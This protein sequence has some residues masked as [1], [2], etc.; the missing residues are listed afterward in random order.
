MVEAERQES[1]ARGGDGIAARFDGGT[2]RLTA[3]PKLKMDASGLTWCVRVKP[4][5]KTLDGGL[6]I[7]SGL[8]LNIELAAWHMPWGPRWNL[9]FF[10]ATPGRVAHAPLMPDQDG[11]W[12]DIVVRVHPLSFQ[13][14]TRITKSFAGW[15]EIFVNGVLRVRRPYSGPGSGYAPSPIQGMLLGR[16]WNDR[17]FL[18]L[19]D[20][21]AVWQRTLTDAEIASLSGVQALDLSL[22]PEDNTGGWHQD[23]GAGFFPPDMPHQQRLDRIRDRTVPAVK[24]LL[25]SDPQFPRYHLAP[26]GSIY[27]THLFHDKGV[28]HMFPTV[29]VGPSGFVSNEQLF[30]MHLTSSDLMSW[31]PHAAH[32]PKPDFEPNGAFFVDA[33]NRVNVVG[34]GFKPFVMQGIATDA[35]LDRWDML[36]R[37]PVPADTPK[38]VKRLDPAV[39]RHQGKWY[40]AATSIDRGES[41]SRIHLLHLS[42]TRRAAL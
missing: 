37:P 11:G 15:T 2:M 33:K 41:T 17:R 22:P 21:L 12:M 7:A 14:P 5:A 28:W 31:K 38:A 1:L 8:P 40:L 25:E 39:F 19:M 10:Q 9:G 35:T 24:A 13:S 18:G 4:S 42:H 20:H 27:N 29:S 34:G 32:F 36:P 30:W 3:P 23:I 16:D 26:P 6:F